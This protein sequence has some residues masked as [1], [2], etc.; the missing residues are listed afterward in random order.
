MKVINTIM[1]IIVLL[2]FLFPFIT[3]NSIA[4]PSNNYTFE[5]DKPLAFQSSKSNNISNTI[6]VDTAVLNLHNQVRHAVGV[7]PVPPLVWNDNLAVIADAWVNH[8]KTINHGLP[9][10]GPLQIPHSQSATSGTTGENIA[11]STAWPSSAPLNTT[12]Q[13]TQSWVNEK[14]GGNHNGISCQPYAEHP[15]SASDLQCYAHYTQIVWRTTTGVGC[16][17]VTDTGTTSQNVNGNIRYLV[18]DYSPPGNI[19]THM[20]Y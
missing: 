10:N 18:C 11:V 16:S 13:L 1:L 6:A 19:F 12:V 15:F 4:I 8:L 2:A 14:N 9:I 7:P 3:S 20:P 5:V 17:T